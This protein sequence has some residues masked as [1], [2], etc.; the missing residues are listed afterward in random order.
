MHLGWRWA[1]FFHWS[2]KTSPR[3]TFDP[4][5]VRSKGVSHI[6]WEKPLKI[7]KLMVQFGVPLTFDSYFSDHLL[8][9]I[10]F[11]TG[12]VSEGTDCVRLWGAPL[13]STLCSVYGT[14]A[15]SM[16]KQMNHQRCDRI[17]N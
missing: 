12:L 6:R 4:R 9:Y 2:G 17:H 11:E 16:R 7:K 15:V 3:V 1:C 10:N 13:A 14:Q 5:A 8:Y